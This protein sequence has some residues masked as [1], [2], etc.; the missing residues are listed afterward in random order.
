MR[1]KGI[2]KVYLTGATD[3]ENGNILEVS[4]Y[5]SDTATL[6]QKINAVMETLD[7]GSDIE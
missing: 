7:D 5:A 1:Y 6:A 4:L 2:A 3:K